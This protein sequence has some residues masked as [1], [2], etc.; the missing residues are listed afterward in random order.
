MATSRI[1]WSFAKAHFYASPKKNKQKNPKDLSILSN[2]K[3]KKKKTRRIHSK[4]E[5]YIQCSVEK[6]KTVQKGF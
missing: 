3:E 6:N 2:I 1:M 4:K 5:K